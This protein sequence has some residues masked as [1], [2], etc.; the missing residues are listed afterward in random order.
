MKNLIRTLIAAAALALLAS[1]ASTGEN[2]GEEQTQQ[3]ATAQP[4]ITAQPGQ[5][6]YS[7]AYGQAPGGY[8]VEA[9]GGGGWQ[10]GFGGSYRVLRFRQL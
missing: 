3:D 4:G 7:Y 8:D 1:C 10:R 9:G 5:D 6:A 2:T